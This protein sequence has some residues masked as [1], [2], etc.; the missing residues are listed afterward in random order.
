PPPPDSREDLYTSLDDQNLDLE[1]KSLFL[2][3][4]C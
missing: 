2:F 1:S 4:R 3:S